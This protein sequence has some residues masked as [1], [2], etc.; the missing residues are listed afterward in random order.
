[1]GKGLI[2]ALKDLNE[3]YDET[4][5]DFFLPKGFYSPG[6][7]VALSA[8]LH[9]KKVKQNNFNVHEE[10]SGYLS[11]M[12]LSQAIWDVSDY[13]K[14]RCNEGINYSIITPLH[15]P[16]M[17]DIATGSI[18]SC[19]RHFT[20]NKQ[21]KGI[22]DLCHVVGELHDN[23]WS[24]GNSSGFSMA[25]KSKV[26]HYEDNYLEFA[27]ADMGFGF[28]NELKRVGKGVA[29]HQEAIQWCVVEGNSSK[30]SNDIDEW[31]Q[32]LRSD[33]QGSHP[34]GGSIPVRNDDNHHQGLGLGHLIKLV[35]QYHGE[36]T[37]ASGDT[38]LYI[39]S[40][41]NEKYKKIENI[42][43]GVAISC[44]FKESILCTDC[45]PEDTGSDD[46]LNNILEQ[47]GG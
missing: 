5:K 39:S 6:Y 10:N 43:Q 4:Y 17:V 44:K 14:N 42:W 2:N 25:Q 32:S 26:P 1:L 38:Y 3:H 41:G 29:N 7:L 20:K 34:F 30:H 40:T 31:A 24:H 33:I 18:N 21:Y 47:L 23:V 8:Y 15:S 16:E 36:M 22:S 45:Q 27:L 12:A 11:A 46:I 19:I 13:T 37:L 9:C 28:F 35:K